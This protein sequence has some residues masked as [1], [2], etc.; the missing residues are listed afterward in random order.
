[1]KT[2]KL[3]GRSTFALLAV[4]LFLA[5][6]MS[7]RA[8]DKTTTTTTSGRATTEVSVDHGEVVYVSGNDLVVKMDNGTVRHFPNIPEDTR[9]DVDGQ[10]L[11]IHDL[12][13]GMKLRRTITTTTTP[14]LVTTVRTIE[15]K[16]FHV[17]PPRSL[18]LTQEDGNRQYTIPEGQKFNIGGEMKD[19]W[20]LKKGMKISATVVT[21][22]P[23]THVNVERV[24]TGKMPPPPPPPANVPILIVY[25]GPLPA[26]APAPTVAEADPTPEALPQTASPLP[27]IGLLGLMSLGLG[28]GLRAIRKSA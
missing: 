24:V 7:I 26:A 10:I 17:T 2:G 11:G 27:L 13:P 19:A 12:K 18:I 8:Q 4:G 3:F 15:G 23:E 28:F 1:M 20:A 25:G 6:T 21:E 5:F 22:V 16:V 14:R 9:I